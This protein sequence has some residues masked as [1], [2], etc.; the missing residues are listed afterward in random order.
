MSNLQIACPLLRALAVNL[1]VTSGAAIDYGR[2]YIQSVSIRTRETFCAAFSL[3][4]TYTVA[5]QSNSERRAKPF[6]MSF[7]SPPVVGTTSHRRRRDVAPLSARHRIP[8]FAQ[9]I[10]RCRFRIAPLSLRHRSVVA[11]LSLHYR[12]AIECLLR[13]P[14]YECVSGLQMFEIAKLMVKHYP[15]QS[16]DFASSRGQLHQVDLYY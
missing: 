8:Y 13:L 16:Y 7:R 5:D 11:A 4:P 12:R 2:R 6:A 1:F 15:R 3:K 10:L 14:V 9:R